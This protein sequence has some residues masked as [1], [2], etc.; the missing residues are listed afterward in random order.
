MAGL[1]EFKIGAGEKGGT[2][3]APHRPR[4]LP[5]VQFIIVPNEEAKTQ[6]FFIVRGEPREVRRKEKG[7]DPAS[8]SCPDLP[9]GGTFTF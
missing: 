1:A 7:R 3:Q 9:F 5:T 4:P 6:R 2:E 8:C